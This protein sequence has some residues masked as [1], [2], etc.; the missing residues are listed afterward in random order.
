MTLKER[1][2]WARD[3]IDEVLKQGADTAKMQYWIGY[4]EGLIAALRD[5]NDSAKGA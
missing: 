1:M 3:K 2:E 5:E 4:L